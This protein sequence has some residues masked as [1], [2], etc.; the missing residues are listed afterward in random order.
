MKSIS[1]FI[2]VCTA[3]LASLSFAQNWNSLDSYQETMSRSDAEEILRTLMI[4][5]GAEDY[6]DTYIK[7]TDKALII[8]DDNQNTEYE[9]RFGTKTFE[10]ELFTKDLKRMKFALVAR[11]NKRVKV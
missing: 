2:L 6:V 10:S 7:V 3:L 1:T 9:F 4:G 8:Q 11:D 5:N